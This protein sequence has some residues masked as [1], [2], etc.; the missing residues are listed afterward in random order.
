MKHRDM[1]VCLV[2]CLSVSSCDSELSGPRDAA[3]GDAADIDAR[4]AGDL[5]GEAISDGAAGDLE[6]GDGGPKPD[7]STSVCAHLQPPATAVVIAPGTDIQQVVD[8]NPAGTAYLLEAG[9]HRMQ[10]IKPQHGDAFYGELDP[11]CKRLTVL[12]GA[13]LLTG[14]TKSGSAWVVGGQTQQGQ[15]HGQCETDWPRCKYP[16]DLYVDDQPVKH[17]DSLSAVGPGTWY[18]DYGADKIYVGDDPSGHTVEVGVTRAAFSPTATHVKVVGLVVEKYAIPPQMGAIGDQYP[19]SDWHIEY[20]EVRLN[21]GTGINIASRTKAINNYVHH[22]GQK[23]IG[24]GGDDGLIDGNEISYNNYAHISSGWEAGGTKF[25]N[26]NRLTVS[27]NCVHHNGGPG[28][29]TDIDNM[30]TLY[31][32]NIAFNN[33]KEGIFHEISFDA[34]IKG[35]LVGQNAEKGVGWLYGAQILIS[36]SKNVEVLNNAVEVNASYGNAIG[37]IWQDRGAA[38]ESTGNDVHD[39]DVTFLG[40]GGEM[41]A[42]SDTAAG[43]AEI[44][45]KNSFDKN[46]YHMTNLGDAHFAWDNGSRTF[47]EFQ[48]K[49]Q[50]VNGTADT[51]VTARSWSC[52]MAKP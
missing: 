18:F 34:V 50:D 49:G 44:F 36:T 9:E 31:E 21:H 10:N 25:A 35:N 11:S 28:L 24:A 4:V 42:A 26:T 8:A 1:V 22:N 23:G 38:Y 39:N 2:V 46:A 51:K 48:A 43:K 5:L 37:I 32:G 7:G 27:N 19:E 6:P 47:A 13:R 29:W 30:D 12:N 14:F 41:G 3:V 40:S 52:S 15:V 16:E 17:V 45:V 33:D 20:N